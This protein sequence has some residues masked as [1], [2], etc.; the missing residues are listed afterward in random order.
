MAGGYGGP[1]PASNDSPSRPARGAD[2]A[3]RARTATGPRQGER[4][5]A[6]V[7]AGLILIATIVPW[8]SSELPLARTAPWLDLW[9]LLLTGVSI[10]PFGP[11]TGFSWL[12]NLLFGLIGTLPTLAL[13]IAM[14]VRA[15]RPAA[16][17][18]SLLR[19]LGI[20]SVLGA[21]WVFLFAWNRQEAANGRALV[22][23]GPWL[24]L[25][26]GA[27]SAVLG[28][29]WWARERVRYPRRVRAEAAGGSEEG[30]LEEVIGLDLDGDGRVAEAE[31][32]RTARAPKQDH[33]SF[34]DEDAIDDDEPDTG[35]IRIDTLRD[36]TR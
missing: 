4:I 2:A 19:D 1:V 20:A 14:A 36:E 17:R 25:A 8:W 21:L 13:L 27:A 9:G 24:M 22:S 29:L 28:G 16:I 7:L 34:T 32:S 18:A 15:I 31:G 33:F 30:R 3:E 11:A 12:G 10:P 23:V 26:L 35:M 5:V 6:A